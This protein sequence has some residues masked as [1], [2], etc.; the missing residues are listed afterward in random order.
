MVELPE[1]FDRL[2]EKYAERPAVEDESQTWSYQQL[3]EDGQSFENCLRLEASLRMATAISKLSEGQEPP[4]A[5][6][7]ALSSA[8]LFLKE[9]KEAKALLKKYILIFSY[10]F[11]CLFM[12]YALF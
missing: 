12:S 1:A 11:I 5:F 7:S 2:A 10:L 9:A 3:Q 8:Q 4:V 6:A